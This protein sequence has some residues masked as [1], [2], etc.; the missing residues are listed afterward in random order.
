M[1]INIGQ[2][3]V[4]AVHEFGWFKVGGELRAQFTGDGEIDEVAYSYQPGESV[5]LDELLAHQ[6]EDAPLVMESHR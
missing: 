5:S 1:H 2:S 3:D 4:F 6:G